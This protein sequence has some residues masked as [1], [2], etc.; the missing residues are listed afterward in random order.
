[1]PVQKDAS[2]RRASQRDTEQSSPAPR[3]G[4][5]QKS[6][7]LEPQ[8]LHSAGLRRPQTRS[9]PRHAPQQDAPYLDAERQACE[10]DMGALRT[11]AAVTP[12]LPQQEHLT[13]ECFE[14]LPR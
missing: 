12:Q 7:A 3:V 14:H 8:T 5:A 10:A 11:T 9:G 4:L 6:S 2:D 13:T 1:M